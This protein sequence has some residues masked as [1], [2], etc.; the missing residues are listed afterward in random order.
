MKLVPIDEV[1]KWIDT[2]KLFPSNTQDTDKLITELYEWF[3]LEEP[4]EGIKL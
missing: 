3:G 1:A 4:K 2:W